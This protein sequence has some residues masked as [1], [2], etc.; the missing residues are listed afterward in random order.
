MKAITNQNN[1]SL[2]T[3]LIAKLGTSQEVIFCVS[4]I[5]DSGVKLLYDY[6]KF[7]LNKN[8]KVTILT[9]T[10][11]NVTE[12]IALY[13]LKSLKSENFKLAIFDS[14]KVKTSF[15]IKGYY[16]KFIDEKEQMII[17]SSNISKSALSDGIEWNI[18]FD[19]T[20]IISDFL[21]HY[22]DLVKNYSFD[23]TDEWLQNYFN[24][25]IPLKIQFDP[26][27]KAD[28]NSGGEG[29]GFQR[30]WYHALQPAKDKGKR[31]QHC[32]KS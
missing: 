18:L 26:E 29:N 3:V 25:Y 16:F 24:T 27:S 11:M 22:N 20:E 4:F 2:E 31:N 12:P 23:L 28:A 17:G 30:V 1:E 10:Y 7:A 14:E 13:R 32:K 21:H 6:L 9:S 8:A 19:N 15:H 5:R